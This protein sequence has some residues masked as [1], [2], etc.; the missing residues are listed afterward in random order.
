L[1]YGLG[2][3][4]YTGSCE[5]ELDF[6]HQNL[7]GGGETVENQN[8]FSDQ[9]IFFFSAFTFHRMF[10]LTARF[11]RVSFPPLDGIAFAKQSLPEAPGSGFHSE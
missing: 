7:F 1:E 5:G 9:L 6:E 11:R 2:K 10:P 8:G 4:L 3:S